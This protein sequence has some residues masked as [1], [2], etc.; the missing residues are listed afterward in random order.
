V[1]KLTFAPKGVVVAGPLSSSL[2][3]PTLVPNQAFGQ[4]WHPHVTPEA[5]FDL[6]LIAGATAGVVAGA[7]CKSVKAAKQRSVPK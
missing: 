1:P 5:S 2:Q 7:V 6:G 3:V 4:I